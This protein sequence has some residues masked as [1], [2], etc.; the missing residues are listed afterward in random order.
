MHLV[1]TSLLLLA[2]H[3]SE[4]PP[5]TDGPAPYAPAVAPASEEAREALARF[6]VPAGF[7]LELFAAEPHLANPVAFAF[8]PHGRVFVAETFRHHKGVTD[9]R[10]HMGWLEDDIAAL[11]VADRVAM[12]LYHEGPERFRERYAVEHERVRRIED[13]DGDGVADA[14]TVF[15]DGFSDPA[16]GIGAGL[17]VRPR[18]GGG[19]DVWF[20][21]IPDLWRLTDADGDGVA[22]AREQHSTGYGVRVALL[23]HDLHGLALGHDGRLYFSIGDRGF[24]VVTREGRT[25][26]H[27]HTGAVLRCELDGA[28]LEVFCTGLRNPQELVFDDNGDLFTGDNNSDGGDQARWTWLLEGS[29]SGWRQAYQWSND[30]N[31]RG[32]WNTEGLWRPWTPAQPAYILPPIANFTSGPSGLTLYPGTGFGPEWEGTFFLCDF[33]GAPAYSGVHAFKNRPRGAGFELVEA[34]EFLWN[35]LPTDVDFGFDGGLYSLDWVNGWNQTGKG[36]VYRLVPE[37]RDDAEVARIR[38]VRALLQGALYERSNE[39]LVALFEHPDRRVRLEAQL[40]LAARAL[41]TSDPRDAQAVMFDALS[42]L[43]DPGRPARAR[44]HAAWLVGHVGRLRP[45]FGQA[46][47]PQLLALVMDDDPELRAQGAK[48]LGELAEASAAEWIELLLEDREPRVRLFAAEAAG[49]LGGRVNP[50]AVADLLQRDGGTDPWLRCVCVRALERLGDVGLVHGLLDHPDAATRRAAVVVLRRWGDP[51]VARALSDA[52]ASV[53]MEAADAVHGARIEAA[54]PDLAGLLQG[55]GVGLSGFTLRR[56]FDA[57]RLVGGESSAALLARFACDGE[58]APELRAAALDVL[59]GW[60]EARTR[61]TVI[62]DRWPLSGRA[63][64]ELTGITEQL[65]R[66][67]FLPSAPDPVRAAWVR[68]S[69]RHDASPRAHASL[70]LLALGASS[71]TAS[72]GDAAVRLAALALL[73]E[74]DPA[75]ADRVATELSDSPERE[76]RAAALGV[77]GRT[78]PALAV[79]KLTAAIAAEDDPA[80]AVRALGGLAAPE[81]RDA[82]LAL[83]EGDGAASA[84]WLVEWF[85]AAASG[86]HPELAQRAAALEALYLEQAAGGDPLAGWRMALTG[87][88][89][90]RGQRIFREHAAVTCTKCHRVAGEGG[91]EAGPDLD[92]VAARLAPEELLRAIVDPNASLAEGYQNWLVKTT[93]DEVF[94][95]RIVSE[96]AELVVLETNQRERIELPVGE[97]ALRKRDVSAMPQDTVSH[98]S[99]R[100]LRDLLAFLQTLN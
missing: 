4:A 41:A 64:E 73:A 92:G 63:A 99:R 81:A 52:D 12:Y 98:L 65:E 59:T 34:R 68:Y 80:S 35:C 14:S 74:R 71:G 97:I 38:E 26:A 5:T 55:T 19:Q 85:E 9:M 32:P 39:G 17:L 2:Q 46:F 82:L 28:N 78:N 21:C 100:E 94:V 36:R 53:V 23:G 24:H 95:G 1:Y 93:D 3:P 33:R 48:V 89:A 6:R 69:A 16:A 91:S 7:R 70:A 15:A 45:E 37:A 56:A 51:V 72:S 8:D 42:M 50:S 57:A 67:L 79:A 30:V 76:V 18:A 90:K 62:Q 84:P 20:T 22:E 61:D 47:G 86:L 27:P 44:M 87:G 31:P 75:T 13:R 58:A 88:A 49:R 29:D 11:T 96:T 25:L 83:V 66:D 43:R 40:A 77:L 10:E 54:F 60:T